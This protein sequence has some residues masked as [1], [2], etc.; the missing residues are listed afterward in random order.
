MPAVCQVTGRRPQTG[1][2]VSHSHRRTKRWWKPNVFKRRFWVPS[3]RRHVT[4]W[5]SAKGLKTIDK[6]G[7]DSVLAEIRARGE[8]V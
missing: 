3:E 2:N 8:K 7:I 1:M 5:V 6:R 4:L